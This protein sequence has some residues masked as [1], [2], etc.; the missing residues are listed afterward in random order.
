MLKRILQT[1]CLFFLLGAFSPCVKADA[2]SDSAV[3]SISWVGTELN[4]MVDTHI[5][6]FVGEGQAVIW[7]IFAVLLVW[8]LLIGLFSQSIRNELLVELVMNTMLGSMM[9]TFY[10][11]PM[12]WGGGFSFHQIFAKEAQWAAGTLDFSLLTDIVKT[13]MTIY[14]SIDLPHFYDVMALIAYVGTLLNLLLVWLFTSGITLIAH[15]ALGFGALVGPLLIPFFIWPVMNW[16]FWGWVRFMTTYALYI[17]SSSAVV[18]LYAHVIM[19]FITHV[20][21]ADYSLGHFSAILLP[22]LMLNAVFMIAFWQCHGWAR[23]L[24]SGSAS[25]GAAVSSMVQAA[26][27]A[28]LA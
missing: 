23:D 10:D 5:D 13:V 20:I 22:F 3:M 19:Y 15:V 4:A 28:I 21:G 2:A 16:L 18:Y 8:Y 14:K 26:A 1:F 12:P 7:S 11:T 25:M 17:I 27:F 6:L 9:L 24:A